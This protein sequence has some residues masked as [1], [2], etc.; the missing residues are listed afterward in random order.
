MPDNKPNILVLWGDDVGITN[1][2]CYSLGLMGDQ[3]P[4]RPHR[5]RGGT[6]HRLLRRAIVY[7]GS[8]GVHHRA[9][10]VPDRVDEGGH[11]GRRP[12]SS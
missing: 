6:V 3:T 7:R 12:L 1:S 9:E 5:G 10:P 2:S 8:G 11:A 4:N